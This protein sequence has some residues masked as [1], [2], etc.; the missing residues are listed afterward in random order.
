MGNF[1]TKAARVAAAFGCA[2]TLGLSVLAI[3]APAQAGTVTPGPAAR[4]LPSDLSVHRLGGF[5]VIP[6]AGSTDTFTLVNYAS[7]YCLGIAG[8][9]PTVGT[10][11][12]QWNCNGN[13]DQQW[14]VRSTTTVD[15]VVFDQLE[16]N[17]NA[18]CLGVSGGSTTEGAKLVGWNCLGTDHQDQWW[19][20]ID[21]EAS[22]GPYCDGYEPIANLK[23]AEAGKTYVIGTQG[24][25]SAEG[26]DL[27]Q[28]NWQKTCNNQYWA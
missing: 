27:V 10:D 18:L 22:G 4:S 6:V 17:D 19:A 25:S 8:G 5:E 20:N 15:G 3:T 2:V 24:G 7:G 23:D 26:A 13:P 21:S 1:K 14:A 11:A 9:S 16:S 12:V 28:W